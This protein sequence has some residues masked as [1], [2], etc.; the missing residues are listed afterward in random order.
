VRERASALSVLEACQGC[1]PALALT[2]TRSGTFI[3]R[4]IL[5]MDVVMLA[6]GFV[7]FALSIGYVYACDQL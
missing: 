6:I 2:D 1:A 4:S 3:A 5:M 7:F